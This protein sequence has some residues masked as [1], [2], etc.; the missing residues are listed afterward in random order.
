MSTANKKLFDDVEKLRDPYEIPPHW[1]LRRQF[2]LLNQDKFDDLDRLIS[3]SK[4][5]VNI[6]LLGCSYNEDVTKLVKEM[7]S[8]VN[9]LDQSKFEAEER[10]EE[11]PKRKQTNNRGWV[12]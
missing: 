10:I 11:S 7:G 5:F 4:C 9:G 6:E 8:Q 1:N 2:I 12:R 3:L